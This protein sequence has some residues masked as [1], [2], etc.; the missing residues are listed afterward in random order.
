[1][2]RGFG[3]AGLALAASIIAAAAQEMK[4]PRISSTQVDWDAA[5]RELASIDSLKQADVPAAMAELNSATGGRFANI[6]ESPVPVLLPFD[7]AA[8]LRE[9][10]VAANAGDGTP[11]APGDYLSGFSAVT[12]FY[13]GPA[14]YDAVVMSRAQEMPELAISYP[15]PIYIHIG[16][17][18]LVYELDEPVGM[19]GWPVHGL[20]GIPGIRRMYLENYVRYTFAVT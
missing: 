18:A 4:S 6:A 19:I 2:L 15:E 1:M 10:A 11:N 17:S 5:V 3:I 12:L 8:F 9:R 16:G 20:E 13:P 7:T 14:G